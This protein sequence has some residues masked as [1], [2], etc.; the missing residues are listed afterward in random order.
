MNLSENRTRAIIA[1]EAADW[2]VANREDQDAVQQGNFAEWLKTSPVHVEEYLGI[3]RLA[4]D[5]RVAVAD[6]ELS[7]D[8]LIERARA[9][10]EGPVRA[11]GAGIT[12]APRSI[13]RNR[14]MYAAAA[15]VVLA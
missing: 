7:I 1:Q 13:V 9:D 15:T 4:G 2:F 14:W 12:R 10:D 11:I 8:A 5:L 3:A 6:P